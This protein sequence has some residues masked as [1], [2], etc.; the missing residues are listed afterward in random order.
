MADEKDQSIK[1]AVRFRPPNKL[2]RGRS[3]FGRVI[4]IL[5]TKTLKINTGKK[6]RDFTFDYVFGENTEQTQVF[7]R[8]GVPL[9]SSVLDGYN[10]TLFAYGQTGSGKTYSME[11][12]LQNDKHQGLLPRITREI[13]DR[14]QDSTDTSVEYTCRV[15]YIEIYNEKFKDLLNP[16]NTD[17]RVREQKG[18]DGVYMENVEQPFVASP[19]EV[20]AKLMEGQLNRS[21]A[22]TRMN[23]HSSRSHAVFMLKITQKSIQTGSLK[24]SKLMMVDLAGS[25]KVRKTN[26]TGQTLKEAQQINKSLMCLG[27][28]MNCLVEGKKHIPYRDSKLTRLLSDAL[29]GNSKTFL[30]T[31]ASP[32]AYNKDETLS[33]LRFASRAKKVQN[34]A[35]VNQELS[36]AQYKIILSQ[37]DKEL[38]ILKNQLIN[39]KSKIDAISVECDNNNI[40]GIKKIIKDTKHK[41]I[42]PHNNKTNKSG[43]SSNHS[44]AT[45]SQLLSIDN[46]QKDKLSTDLS[47]AQED[48]QDMKDELTALQENENVLKSKIENYEAKIMEQQNIVQTLKNDITSLRSK[49]LKYEPYYF[50]VQQTRKQIQDISNHNVALGTTIMELNLKL[51][52][53]NNNNSSNNT[54]NKN[55]INNDDNKTESN[56]VSTVEEEQTLV[57]NKLRKAIDTYYT[58]VET[59][60]NENQMLKNK[61]KQ[62]VSRDNINK[63]IRNDWQKHMSELENALI[64]SSKIFQ[65][66][67]RRH[68]EELA[69][70]DAKIEQLRKF[71]LSLTQ[72]KVSKNRK[73]YKPITI[74][75]GNTSSNNISSNGNINGNGTLTRQTHHKKRTSSLVKSRKLSSS[76]SNGINNFDAQNM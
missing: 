9:V 50:E 60:S 69:E 76:P 56:N 33:T 68:E 47:R 63:A 44:K 57:V 4:E 40:D 41:L 26:A 39:I 7:Q 59:L 5:N 66:E 64:E 36:I 18:K 34:K 32:C 24:N 1:V 74:N 67:K 49:A 58:K 21:V 35:K 13:F 8:I 11:G 55:R 10:C 62:L 51:K 22:S 29:G 45:V 14:I 42:I 12:D 53:R 6:T 73:I 75:N 20:F 37:R 65:S 46:V 2:E 54:R 71:C 72:T 25:E 30:L 70:R 19:Y 61:Y 27:L 48:L 31:A 28:V 43:N 15:S 23:E 52:L 17:I 16:R 3:D 38:N